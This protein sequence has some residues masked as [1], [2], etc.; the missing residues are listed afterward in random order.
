MD[1]VLSTSDYHLLAVTAITIVLFSWILH[2]IMERM[3]N[4]RPRITTTVELQQM[5]NTADDVE[6]AFEMNNR[7]KSDRE[8]YMSGFVTLCI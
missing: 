7:Y 5:S 8:V 1:Y 2:E 4:M 3:Y 6:K